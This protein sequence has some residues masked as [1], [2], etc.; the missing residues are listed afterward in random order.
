MADRIVIEGKII[1]PER[2]KYERY[3][4]CPACEG[5]DYT[6]IEIDKEYHIKCHEA[7]CGYEVGDPYTEE[8][9]K[10]I[11]KEYS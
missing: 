3:G 4:A 2:K 11:I 8:E 10:S 7:F 5:K 1:Y 6:Y 9:T